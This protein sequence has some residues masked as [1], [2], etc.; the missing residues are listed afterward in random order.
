M[1]TLKFVVLAFISVTA[2]ASA[3]AI[4]LAKHQ[5]VDLSH[6]YGPKTLYWPTAPS[7]FVLKQEAFGK[8]EGGWFYS[9]NTLCTPEHGGT[10]LDAPM[11]FSETGWSAERI[12]LE[13]G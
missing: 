1:H 8:T 12:P 6:A 4:D 11:H 13:S 9:A 10:H 2:L 3:Q 7:K 5:I